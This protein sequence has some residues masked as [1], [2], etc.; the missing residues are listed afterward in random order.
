MS[1][2]F[3]DDE[4]LSEKTMVKLDLT[5]SEIRTESPATLVY[6]LP[7]SKRGEQIILDKAFTVGR[8]PTCDI[9]LEDPSVS[10]KHAQFIVDPFGVYIKDLRST[11]K[12]FLDR[13]PIPSE[14]PIL[15]G[16]NCSIRF[17]STVFMYYKRGSFE[18][19]QMKQMF[20]DLYLD[21]LTE[22]LNRR[23]LEERGPELLEKAIE[24]K[25]E[26]S[27]LIFDIDFFKKVNDTYG[28][29]GGDFVLKEIGAVIQNQAIRVD[30]LFAR[31]GGE[32]FVIS[33]YGA[34]HVKAQE[35]AERIRSEV[36]AYQFVFNGTHIP[37]TIS[38]GIAQHRSGE[39][40]EQM[41][42]RADQALYK[43]KQG[44]RNRAT[45]G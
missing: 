37:V 1:G 23:A 10:K 13:E 41:L 21:P 39:T 16:S 14:K 6:W 34:D 9:V 25:T 44:G 28:H 32:E 30:D 43:S 5:K 7:K 11:N 12:T 22:T 31:Y 40:W 36:E 4:D 27:L 33:L 8:I 45:L 24:N 18:A 2:G 15:L 3:D 17:G 29:Q 38:L 35:I 19:G 26:F 20:S 42:E